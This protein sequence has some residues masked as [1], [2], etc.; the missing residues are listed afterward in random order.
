MTKGDLGPSG[1]T[2]EARRRGQAASKFLQKEEEL[3]KERNGMD[4][5]EDVSTGKGLRV[6]ETLLFLAAQIQ[7]EMRRETRN[8]RGWQVPG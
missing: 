1:N 3:A 7:E 4:F 8:L 2:K 5:R 6:R